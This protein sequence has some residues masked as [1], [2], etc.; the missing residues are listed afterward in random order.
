MVTV[1]KEGNVMNSIREGQVANVLDR[2]ALPSAPAVM[3]GSCLLCGASAGRVVVVEG[4]YCGR[5]CS[6]GVV[7][8]DPRP[9]PGTVHFAADHHIETYY[10]LPAKVRLDWVA[11][12]ARSG[13]ILEIGC[14]EGQFLALAQARGY[15]VAAIEPNRQ[16]AD[17]AANTLGIDVERALVEESSL[18]PRQFDVVFH[19]DLLS[20]FPDPVAALRKMSE[21]VKP[22]GVV[23]FE[24]GVFGGLSPA[25]YPFV[26]RIGYPQHLWLYSEQ[27]IRTVV[28]RAGLRVERVRRFGLAPATLLSTLGNHFL[29]SRITR[30]R[31]VAGRSARATR[32]YRAYGWLQYVLRYHVGRFVPAVGPYAMLVTARPVAR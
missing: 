9:D 1:A 13:R 15:G 3:N 27:A 22:D 17:V 5:A 14:G 11:K 18:A 31:S 8:I 21:L 19:V 26:G 16:A 25:W 6:C 10:S 4:E 2:M 28:E 24:V 23:C 32:F 20:H 30:P 29:R 7:Y 12:F